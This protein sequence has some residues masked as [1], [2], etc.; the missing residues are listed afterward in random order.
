MLDRFDLLLL[1]RMQRDSSQTAEQLAGSVPLSPSAIARRLRRLRRDRWIVRTMALLSGRLTNDRLRALIFV[2]LSE[3]ADHPGK[4]ALQDRLLAT[5]EVQFVYDLA[6]PIDVVVMFDCPNM[7]RFNELT[8][9][10]LTVDSTVRRYETHFV[11]REVKFEPFV[12]LAEN[13]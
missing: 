13:G 5:P 3:H 10:V 1:N 4:A 6:G 7:A 11:K 2:T 12:Q 8:E 9:Q